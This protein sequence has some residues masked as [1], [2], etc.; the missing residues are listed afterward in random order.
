MYQPA[1]THLFAS[2]TTGTVAIMA[3]GITVRAASKPLRRAR[4]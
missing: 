1:E 3:M 2:P 4:K